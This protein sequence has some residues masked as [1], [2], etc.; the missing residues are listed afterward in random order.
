ME[1]K[2][3]LKQ[4]FGYDEFRPH[5]EEIV[6]ALVEGRD[7][8][9]VMPT[10]GGKSLCY[11]LPAHLREGTC[12]VISPLISLMKDQV[13]AAAATGLRAA[14]L[15][16]SLPVNRQREVIDTLQTG[17][18]DLLYVAPER[19]AAAGFP[20]A[21]AQA[22]I[23]LFAIDEAHCIS[24]WGHD[25]RPDYLNLSNLIRDFPGVPVAAFTATATVQVQ[26]DIVA[27]LGLRTPH[28]VRASFDRP[29]LHY[30]VT[31]KQR[32]VDVQILN[33]VREHA[34]E[35]GI[36]YRTTRK[37]VEETCAFLVQN[38][39]P[40]LP[41]H[42]GMEGKDRERNQ[43]AYRR[44]DVQVVVATVAFGMG[45]DKPNVR[46]II[47]GDLPKNIESYY[48]ETGRA[49]RDG[50]PA[51]CQLFYAPQDAG[52]ITYFIN[53]VQDPKEQK[54]LRQ[55][56][57]AM[58]TYAS[59]HACRRI[60]LLRYFGEKYR[61]K[62]CQSC[63]VCVGDVTAVDATEDAQKL[64]SA[65][66][67]TNQ[68]YGGG[69][70]IDIVRGA[71]TEAIRNAGDDQI[72]TYAVG[73]D[74]PKKHWAQVLDNLE[75]RECV[76]RNEDSQ[77]PTLQMT[78]KGWQVLRGQKPFRILQ[79]AQT[80]SRRADSA[81]AETR[82]YDPELFEQ[83]RQ[84]RSDK[85]AQLD[86]PAYVV[87][88]NRTL[89]EISARKPSDIRQLGTLHGVGK[90]KL[91][92]HGEDIIALVGNFLNSNPNSAVVSETVPAQTVSAE[93]SQTHLHSLELFKRGLDMVD[94]AAERKLAESTI[95]SHLEK[96]IIA[97]C[98][99]DHTRLVSPELVDQIGAI[100]DELGDQKL[101]P[102]VEMG[103]EQFT[104]EHAKIVRALRQRKRNSENAVRE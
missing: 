21:L 50:D 13:D 28:R 77:F 52:R 98:E 48:Q 12:L 86:V 58:Q 16:S 94:I 85:A 89:R 73:S 101:A 33:F 4:L 9:V 80:T 6:K 15:N 17:N 19:F 57:R 44:D 83:L 5:Q 95:A 70:I 87:F 40:A 63:D 78:D 42:A 91:E 38:D 11:Q 84:W 68:R 8:F 45:I 31:P 100:M 29:N 90:Q 79:P 71:N 55:L 69:R 93:L 82:T 18:L 53:Q 102:I 14:F 103:N 81:A 25:F 54:R 36:I 1:P 20:E 3:A 92:Q 2:Q 56:L 35:P 76:V 7:A 60:A 27:R 99:M 64:M 75:A 49:G 59:A 61:E 30:A 88:S 24:E 62:N 39:I 43:E 47:H 97:G 32:N 26:D 65:M 46:W 67:R 51:R 104:F 41:Y 74:K 10:G 34:D 37:A 23:T 22:Q 66:V 96:A 72:K